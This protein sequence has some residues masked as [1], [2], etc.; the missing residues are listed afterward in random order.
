MFSYQKTAGDP[1]LDTCSMPA[2]S[3]NSGQV[4]SGPP[5]EKVNDMG[6]F[7]SSSE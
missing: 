2:V 6:P 5:G 4:Y 1:T 7:L 3:L